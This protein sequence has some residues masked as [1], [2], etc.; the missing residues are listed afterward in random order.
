MLALGGERADKITRDLPHTH[1]QSCRHRSLG[2]VGMGTWS[3][4]EGRAG[5][6]S[7]PRR[8]ANGAQDLICLMSGC[9]FINHLQSWSLGC[10]PGAL[11]LDHR[12]DPR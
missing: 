6:E 12:G 9:D 4:A 2:A 1:T 8:A 10:V 5:Q 11:Q 3:W 7:F